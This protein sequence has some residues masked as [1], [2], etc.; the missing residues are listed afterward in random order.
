MAAVTLLVSLWLK[1]L[2]MPLA[3]E[4]LLA[5]LFSLYSCRVRKHNYREIIKLHP[6]SRTRASRLFALKNNMSK[7]TQDVQAA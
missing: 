5:V 2:N 1:N 4:G 6:G 3:E 7:T